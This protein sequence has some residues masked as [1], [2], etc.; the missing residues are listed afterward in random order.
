MAQLDPAQLSGRLQ[1]FARPSG[2][3]LK[4]AAD[5]VRRC[6]AQLGYQPLSDAASLSLVDTTETTPVII[7]DAIDHVTNDVIND[8]GDGGDGA[9]TQLAVLTRAVD[10]WSVEVVLTAGNTRPDDL[11]ALTLGYVAD[12]GGGTLSWL[13]QRA[14]DPTREIATHHGFDVGREILQLRVPLPLANAET[15]S[16]RAFQV[17]IDEA[18]WLDVNNAA[19]AWHPEQG[20]WDLAAVH[21][22]E[23]TDWFDADGFRMHEIDGRLAASCWTKVHADQTPVLGE[24]YVISVHPQF[25][26]RGLGRALTAA[27]LDHLASRCITIGMLYVDASNTPAVK[28]YE[29]MGFQRH[30][31]DIV[32]HR[33]VLPHWSVADLHESLTARTF[34]DALEHAAAEMTRAR[35]VFDQHD[36]RATPSRP[37]VAADGHAA[38]QAITALNEAMRHV[39]ELVAVVAT[40]T[41]TNSF[42]QAAQ[43]LAG[44]L[45]SISARR[46]PLQARLADWVNALGVD[47]LATVST[48]VAEHLEPLTRL[49]SRASHQMSEAEEGLYAELSTTGASAWARLHGDVTSQLSATVELTDG[50]QVLPM[51]AV[52]GLATHRDPA[53]R[54]AAYD[55]ELATWP[56]VAGVAAAA[57]NAIKGDANVVNARRNWASPLEASLFANS[58]SRATFDALQSAVVASLPDFRAWM[59]VKAGAL[60]HSDGLPWHELFAPLPGVGDAVTWSDGIGLVGDA[61]GSYGGELGGLLQRALDGRWIDAEPRSGKR[62]GAFCA[63]LTGTRSLVFLNWSDSI[64]SIR[65]LAHELGHA[66]HNVQL[67]H[68]SP[69]QRQLPMSLAETASIFCETL[70]VDRSLQGADEARQLA[71]LDA[72][73]IG[74][75]QVVVDIHSRFLF[76]TELFAR[77]Q[78]R[79]IGA[80]DL[81]QMMRD[82]Q[83]AAY[84]DGLDQRTAHPY[85]WIV[86]PHYYSS[87]FYNWPYTF[88]LLFG[89][90]LF[91]Q[92]RTDSAAFVDRYDALLSRAS[93]DTAEDLGASFGIDITD[94]AFWTTSLDVIR[95]RMRTY[96]RLVTEVL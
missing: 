48:E 58:V 90:G 25:Q 86:K 12:N 96:A 33:D 92:Y 74:A 67:A 8:G 16:T 24:I 18:A 7:A 2:E 82:A 41:T 46:R 89:L 53:V 64:D 62:G 59:R 79:T 11:L 15:V 70:L 71:I 20:G 88:G 84:G 36:I 66:Y 68:R 42:D 49:A 1:V 95:E 61:F 22:R 9:L 57:I 4:R 23:S 87:H 40:V 63:R 39:D 10:G 77:R 37:V 47:A 72:D 28:L 50:A 85:M 35:A 34:T 81:Q 38:D 51:A 60:G 94:V 3:A 54:R 27:G 19:F 83:L 65:T 91:A 14:D 43:G 76:E 44:E 69:L 31:A 78:R 73:L 6:E 32:F 56:S 21:L 29:S 52:R 13:A 30:H 80:D 45:D 26:G 5:L 93:M 75:N 55:A 17:G